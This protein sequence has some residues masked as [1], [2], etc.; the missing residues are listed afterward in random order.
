MCAERLR[1]LRAMQPPWRRPA[2]VRKIRPK[3]WSC[4]SDKQ[5][6]DFAMDAAQKP[7]RV[8]L[9]RDLSEFLVELSIAL[10][11]HADVPRRPPVA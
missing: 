11:K 2:C 3:L 1:V 9:S 7:E 8:T 6:G 10:H 5:R 4:R